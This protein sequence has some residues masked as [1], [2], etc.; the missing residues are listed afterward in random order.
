MGTHEED[1]IEELQSTVY[2]LPASVQSVIEQVRNSNCIRLE[3]S[4]NSNNK[5]PLIPAVQ[6]FQKSTISRNFIK[7]HRNLLENW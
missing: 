2:T 1:D 4:K 3:V 5:K 6:V 7:I